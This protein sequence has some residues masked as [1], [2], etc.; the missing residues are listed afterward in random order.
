[1]NS[2]KFKSTIKQMIMGYLFL[3]LFHKK[4][5]NYSIVNENTPLLMVHF[6]Y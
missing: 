3:V 6:L 1:M 4:Q 5:K 2:K